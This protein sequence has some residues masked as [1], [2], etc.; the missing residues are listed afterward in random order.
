[1]MKAWLSRRLGAQAGLWLDHLVHQHVGVQ[2]A[3]DEHLGL[4]LADQLD[5][6][7]GGLAV[8]GGLDDA[9]RGDVEPCLAAISAIRPGGP[10]RTGSISP[11]SAAST[12]AAS[13]VSSHGKATAARAG[14]SPR[15][16]SSSAWYLLCAWTATSGG[17]G[18]GTRTCSAGARTT[19]TPA[20]T[21]SLCWLTHRQSNSTTRPSARFSRA[22]TVAVTVSPTRTGPRNRRSWRH[23]TRCPDRGAWSRARRRSARVPEAVADQPAREE[24]ARV[25]PHRR[26][27]G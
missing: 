21:A 15:Q 20:A 24:V 4:A 5:G 1:M 3:L 18:Q 23:D 13:D 11:A 2:A 17:S 12:A 6:A 25:L 22:V 27:S 16:R 9:E 7:G 8:V 14:V 26:G 19:A 10:T